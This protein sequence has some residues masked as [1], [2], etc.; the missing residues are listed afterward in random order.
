MSEGIYLELAGQRHPIRMTLRAIR[1]LS[2]RFGSLDNMAKALSDSSDLGA[3]LDAIN[4]TLKILLK[5]GRAWASLTGEELPPALTCEPI[6]VI[7]MDVANTLSLIMSAMR[8]DTEREVET[9][10]KNGEAT[11]D[12]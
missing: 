9:V 4:D 7:D 11:R 1:D 8:G 12:L 5:A 2:N 10:P 6:D 3:L